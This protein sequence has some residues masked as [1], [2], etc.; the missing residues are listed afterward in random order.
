[1]LRTPFEE[2]ADEDENEDDFMNQTRA[3][4]VTGAV[5]AEFATAGRA[6]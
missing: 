1:M 2:E 5:S 6:V 4:R 3:G